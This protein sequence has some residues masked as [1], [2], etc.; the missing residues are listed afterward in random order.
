[1][2]SELLQFSDDQTVN[3]DF[4]SE[5]YAMRKTLLVKKYPVFYHGAQPISISNFVKFDSVGICS[6][7]I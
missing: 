4:A 3:K 6:Y 2:P 7:Q 1:M 5:R